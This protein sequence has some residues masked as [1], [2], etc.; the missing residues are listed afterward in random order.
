MDLAES[1]IKEDGRLR[2]QVS[3]NRIQ[4]ATQCEPVVRRDCNNHSKNN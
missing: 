4:A 1:A 2:A 3:T